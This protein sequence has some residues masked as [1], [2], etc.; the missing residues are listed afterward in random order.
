MP[1]HA[2]PY[3]SHTP[4]SCVLRC[5]RYFKILVSIKRDICSRKVDGLYSANRLRS[6]SD[7][8]STIVCLPPCS[9]TL[10]VGDATHS[11]APRATATTVVDPTDSYNP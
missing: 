9:G 8:Y 10:H 1:R 5:L 7:G 4:N 2:L 11:R 6:G 3:A